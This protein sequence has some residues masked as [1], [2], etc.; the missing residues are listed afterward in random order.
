MVDDTILQKL[1]KKAL[2]NG[3]EYA[4]IFIEHRK[5]TA[6]QLEDDKIEKVIA[7]SIVGIGIR[8]IYKAKTAYAYSNDLSES[9]L[10]D[11]ADTVSKAAADAERDIVV[12]MKRR[13][14]ETTFIIKKYP[15][16][17]P[18]SEKIALVKIGNDTARK[19]DPK[20]KQV[21]IMYKDSMQ[22]IKIYTSEGFVSEDERVYTLGVVQVIAADGEIIQTGYEPVS[23]LMGYELF[24]EN[25]IDMVALKAAQRAVMMLRAKRAPGGRMSVVISS[26]AGGTMVHEAIG[27]GL[28]ADLAQ[29][30]LSVYSRKVGQQVASAAVTVIDDAT[31]P[32]KRGSFSFDDEGTPSRRNILV[33]EGILQGYMYDKYTAM[34]DGTL[35][36]G[37]GRRES[38]EHKPVPRMTNTFIAPGKLSC[39]EIIASVNKGLMVKKMGGGQ[40]NTVTGDFVFEVQE[41]Y[42]IE[43][44]MVGEPV[45]GATLIGNGPEI[46]MSIDM[47]ASD[48]GFSVGTCGK[49]GQG[50]PVSDAMPTIRIPEMV[51]GGEISSIS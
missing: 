49:D 4:D 14:P 25:P 40:V 7:G 2:S 10:M 39:D 24:D 29:Q 43:N 8:L 11:I 5:S 23:G 36:T 34:I 18:V 47:V 27:H 13:Y 41:G 21:N 35:S 28:E 15:E 46:L 19:F 26:E 37:N 12:N 6:I 31:L 3:G 48:I 17:V 45:R 33:K 22:K 42:I 9:V 20:I 32:N 16:T 50:V 38:Y 44:G 1:I 51:V 30:G